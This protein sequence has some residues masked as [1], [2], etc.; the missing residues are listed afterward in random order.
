VSAKVSPNLATGNIWVIN[1][2]FHKYIYESLSKEL[3][4]ADK[5]NTFRRWSLAIAESV[6]AWRVVPRIV[7]AGYSYLIG[8]MVLYF[9]SHDN[10]EHVTCDPAVLKVLLDANTD[11]ATATDIACRVTDIIGPPDSLTGIVGTLI[12]AGAVVFGLYSST[13]KKWDGGFSPWRLSLNDKKKNNNFDM[14]KEKDDE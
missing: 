13:S 2:Y 14:S 7:V 10:V 1:S 5:I 3:S 12:G 11:L 4:M 9:L 8:Y 6:D